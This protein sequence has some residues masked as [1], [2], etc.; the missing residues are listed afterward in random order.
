MMKKLVLYIPDTEDGLHDNFQ[1]FFKKLKSEIKT[2]MMS[3]TN[4][5]CGP[6]DLETLDMFLEAFK[7]ATLIPEGCGDLI[8]CNELDK[9]QK[10]VCAGECDCCNLEEGCFY[11]RATTIIP[12]DKEG[13]EE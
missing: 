8:D 3:R 10:T 11:N 12:S 5:V 13:F 7:S 9:L 2:H 6:C 4:L 1:F